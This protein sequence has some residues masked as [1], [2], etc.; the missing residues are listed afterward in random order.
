VRAAA[1][2]YIG[3]VETGVGLVP[4]G[5][6]C[7]ELLLRLRL[8]KEG[9][10]PFPPARRAFETIAYATVSTSA[11]EARRLG[12]L[13]ATDQISLDRERLLF[14]ARADAISLAEGGYAAPEP[15]SLLLPGTGGRLVL[16]QQIDGLRQTG[17]ISEH[18]GI[19]AGKLAFVLTGGECS[20]V[21][22]VAEQWVLDLEREAF[23]SLAGMTR[24]QERI[25]YTLETGKPLRN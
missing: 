22:P 18:D 1:E 17:K 16:D 19:V 3:L 8:G 6:G 21:R 5:G 23:L 15:A 20:P 7:K 11:A 13:G 9:H 14:D 2:S 4:A 25:K 12:F 10:G 24:T